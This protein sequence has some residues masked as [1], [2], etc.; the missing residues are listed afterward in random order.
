MFAKQRFE[1]VLFRSMG[2]EGDSSGLRSIFE[3]ESFLLP[4]RLQIVPLMTTDTSSVL[5]TLTKCRKVKT[6][7]RKESSDFKHVERVMF[8][9]AKKS[10]LLCLFI[11]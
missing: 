1:P 7:K 2:R 11:Y 6:E 3:F 9:E 8:S 5:K 4:A 10:I